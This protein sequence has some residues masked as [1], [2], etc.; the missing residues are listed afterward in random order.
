DTEHVPANFETGEPEH[1]ILLPD[2]RCP[3]WRRTD[4]ATVCC[5]FL[6][7]EHADEAESNYHALIEAHFGGEEKARKR[8]GRSLLYDEFKICGIHSE[9][10]E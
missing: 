6:G 3:Y 9:D 8:V 4:H 2:R 10:D 5:D 1:W 7:V